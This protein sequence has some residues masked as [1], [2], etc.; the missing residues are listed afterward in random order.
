[1]SLNETT[2]I[3]F[4][5]VNVTLRF[6]FASKQIILQTRLVCEKLRTNQPLVSII[7]WSRG[8]I[9]SYKSLPLTILLLH[10]AFSLL[11]SI[12]PVHR[13]SDRPKDFANDGVV[14]G[15]PSHGMHPRSS[16]VYQHFSFGFVTIDAHCVSLLFVNLII[17]GCNSWTKVGMLH[18]II[19]KKHLPLSSSPWPF[20][21]WKI[22]A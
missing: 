22:G 14:A 9:D 19:K 12:S 10:S 20:L 8:P 2:I 4:L 7:S 18:S 5:H 15:A 11:F 3:S 6:S 13:S 21:R 17:I 1:M 16:L